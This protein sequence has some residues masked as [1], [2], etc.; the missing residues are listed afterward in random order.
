MKS[1]KMKILV[2]IAE[3]IKEFKVFFDVIQE[4]VLKFIF[5]SSVKNPISMTICFDPTWF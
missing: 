1:T 5:V 3:K 2:L 4:N